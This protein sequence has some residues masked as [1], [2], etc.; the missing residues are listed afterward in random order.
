MCNRAG[1][2][3]YHRTLSAPRV[4][5]GSVEA[6][7]RAIINSARSGGRTRR[8][9]SG[10]HFRPSNFPLTYGTVSLDHKCGGK[11]CLANLVQK[12]RICPFAAFGKLDGYRYGPLQCTTSMRAV[13][14]RKMCTKVA[15]PF[16]CEED[17]GSTKFGSTNAERKSMAP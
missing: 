17:C 3:E 11:K 4:E 10:S 1:G 2:E 7:V 9:S 8:N 13:E 6:L 5:E 16:F 12:H 15:L 14:G